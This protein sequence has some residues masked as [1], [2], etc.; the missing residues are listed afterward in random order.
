LQGSA[1]S[2]FG[3]ASFLLGYPSSGQ[4]GQGGYQASQ[5]TFYEMFIQDDI[6][7]TSSLT[8]NLGVRWEYQGATT[9]RFDRIMRNFD[10]TIV[11][12]LSAAAEA[13]YAN[14]PI[15]QLPASDFRVRGGAVWANTAGAGRNALD[16][17]LDNFAP[18][19]GL[20]Y[21]LN[22]RTVWR[23]GYGV[24]YNPR[25]T[26]VN[27]RGFDVTT[28]MLVCIDG[29]TPA[30]DISNPF[31][32]RLLAAPGAG[33]SPAALVGQDANFTNPQITTPKISNW[34]TGFQ[35]Q[36][37]S[38]LVIDASYVG[39]RTNRL[40][41]GWAFNT[42]DAKYL[43]LGSELN[44]AVPNPFYGLIPATAGALGQRTVQLGQLLR[45]F[46]S[47]AN[48]NGSIPGTGSMIYHAAQ[49]S[50]EKRFS[51][52]F[53]FLGSY[54]FSKLMDKSTFMNSGYSN[55]YE[56]VIADIDRP[57][58]LVLSGVYELPFGRGKPIASAAPSWLNH[59]VGGWQVTHVAAF[60]SGRPLQAPS[61]AIA[62]GQSAALENPTID[63][64][65]NTAAFA[66][67]PPF[68]LRTLSAR[69]SDVRGAGINNWDISAIKNTQ[70]TERIRM[71]FRAEFFNA[72]NR[73]QFDMPDRN[74]TGGNF[75][76][77]TG[78]TN[79]PRQI[80][81]GLRLLF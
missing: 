18:R 20:A 53:S 67:Q 68:T 59:V 15:P 64:W 70:L 3:T 36:L 21:Q 5:T 34:S 72:F 52:G 37:S 22:N 43:S 58:R 63:R 7:L 51:S 16:P 60:Q 69:L 49:L 75:G 62:T 50:I 40:N 38:T 12:P 31:P 35:T 33:R 77:V 46:P 25:S 56:S 81:F 11:L 23:A 4:V 1:S 55:V 32:E 78:Q 17:E 80:Q 8:L 48:V 14:S 76:K 44:R 13:A 6:R 41:P 74:V 28:P 42:Y 30:R 24:F 47:Y 71:Q 73:V 29:L 10:P 2:G 9:E 27:M 79:I 66:V 61:N 39:T 54:T 57:Q 65:F 26:G 45:P 19:I